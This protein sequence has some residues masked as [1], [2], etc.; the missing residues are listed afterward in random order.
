MAQ[1]A[2]NG[3]KPELGITDKERAR[4]AKLLA[5]DLAD[6]FVLAAKTRK[7]HWNVTGDSFHELHLLFDQHYEQLEGSIDEIAEYIRQI[8][9]KSP[10]T[11][12]EYLELTQLKEHPGVNPSSKQMIQELLN[13][14]ETIIRQLRKDIEAAEDYNEAGAADFLTGLLEEHQKMAW[15]LRAYLEKD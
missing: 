10:G 1:K 5:R 12:Q 8:G 14:H 4:V 11:L 9:F 13:D 2:K 6:T 3:L 15:F 7:F